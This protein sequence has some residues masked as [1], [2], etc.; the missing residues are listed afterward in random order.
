[1]WED[2]ILGNSP[3]SYENSFSEIKRWMTNKGLLCLA[4]ICSWDDKGNWVDWKFL[5]I[6][7]RLIS[8]QSNLIKALSGLAPVHFSLKD[9][10][11]SREFGVYSVGHGYS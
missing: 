3:L 1:M 6:P 7:D 10:W 9:K 4:G 8:D 5:E 11:G 2:K